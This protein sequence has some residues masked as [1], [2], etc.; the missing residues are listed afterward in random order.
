M[1]CSLG[2]TSCLMLLQATVALPML[3]HVTPESAVALSLGVLG[4][5]AA[6]QAVVFML[7]GSVALL[8]DVIHNGGDALT[9]IPLGIAF[10]APELRNQG[11]F[12]GATGLCVDCRCVDR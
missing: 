12:I 8:A 4:F 10:V 6:I 7:S 5:T 1:A 11:A 2:V 3:G 9:A